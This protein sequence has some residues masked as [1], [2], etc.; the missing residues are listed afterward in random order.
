MDQIPPLNALKSFEAAARNDG[1]ARAA[2][3]LCVTQSAVSH[4]VRQ[5]EEW[6]GIR[7]FERTGG[8][9]RLTPQ[10]E[11][12]AR[13]LG[14]AF[15]DIGAACRRISETTAT[16]PLNIAVIPSVAACWLIPRMPE[17]MNAH[18]HITIRLTYAIHGQPID[19]QVTD[20]ALVYAHGRISFANTRATPIFPGAAAPVCSQLFLDRH[21]PLSSPKDIAKVPLLH[22][23][24]WQGWSDWFLK[25]TGEERAAG[26]GVVFGDFHLMRSAA[27]SGQGVA[28]CPLSIIQDD[29]KGGRLVS[30][31]GT[32]VN[33]KSAY[34]ILE[35]DVSG[36][37]P[38]PNVSAFKTWLLDA[39]KGD[40]PED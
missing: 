39:A 34:Y 26:D 21:G 3:E 5:L 35:S 9:A 2:D 13:S 23:T 18:P 19:F 38:A 15:S 7:L 20:V 10:G 24:D 28:L 16:E 6:F 30:L 14:E 33:E 12:L 22:D 11:R 4:Q 31:S 36:R 29:L 17:F 40:A 1:F 27:L 37:T 32:T 25:T 8:K